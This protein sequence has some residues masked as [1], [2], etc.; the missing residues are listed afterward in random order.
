MRV[1]PSFS[2]FRVKL[3]AKSRLRAP[4]PANTPA[5]ASALLARAAR[6]EAVLPAGGAT[7]HKD[8]SVGSYTLYT[9]FG[10]KTG[11]SFPNG[12]NFSQ[13]SI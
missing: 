7:M 2:C 9:S 12:S 11:N 13:I 8:N 1:Y 10:Q 5:G 6:P 3:L 4:A